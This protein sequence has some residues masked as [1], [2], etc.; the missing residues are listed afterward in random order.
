MRVILNQ[1]VP[2]VGKE[3][4]VVRVA[5]GYARNYLFPRGLAILADKKQLAVIERRRE[6]LAEADASSVEGAQALK[7]KLDGKSI[8]IEAKAGHG[9]TK[10]FG[11]VT[12]QNIADALKEQLKVSLEKKQVA[13]IDPIKRLGKHSV[14]LDLHREVDAEIT[15]EVFDPNAPVI[16]EALPEYIAELEGQA[17]S[18]PSS[19]KEQAEAPVE[20][21]EPAAKKR[22]K[23]KPEEPEAQENGEGESKAQPEP[24]SVAA[25]ATEPD[26]D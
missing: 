7:E 10:L 6:R 8:R 22:V 15:L 11:A 19:E 20:V 25:A 21:K 26:R 17:E 3:G 9:T 18:A 12:S 14:H 4:Q 5:R 23:A 16:E 13:L 24:D 1:T 2:K